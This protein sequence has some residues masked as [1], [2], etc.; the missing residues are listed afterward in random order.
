METGNYFLALYVVLMSVLSCAYY[1]RFV[2]F[3]F[4][5]EIINEQPI[6]FT[7]TISELQ[8]YLIAFLFIINIS[9]IFL[10]GPILI[11]FDNIFL[12]III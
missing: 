1:I 3:I 4:F 2:R 11:L 10:Q 7:N 8:A 6:T 5:T 9:F 12:N